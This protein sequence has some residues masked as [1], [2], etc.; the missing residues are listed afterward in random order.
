[1]TQEVK[2]I[3]GNPCKVLHIC[4]IITWH[5]L[6]ELR[7][8][9]LNLSSAGS[10]LRCLLYIRNQKVI[11][12][13]SNIKKISWPSEKQDFPDMKNYIPVP[14]GSRLSIKIIAPFFRHQMH[15]STF[16]PGFQCLVQVGPFG[17]KQIQ[18]DNQLLSTTLPNASIEVICKYFLETSII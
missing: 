10:K 5:E 11:L 18:T 4:V 13:P 14:D 6:I 16:P 15:D 12:K 8:A 9:N 3:S 17:S 7:P 1:M 2:S